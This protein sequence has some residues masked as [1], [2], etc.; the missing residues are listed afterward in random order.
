MVRKNK[1]QENII[2]NTNLGLLRDNFIIHDDLVKY[3]CEVERKQLIKIL[4]LSD[5][6]N[7]QDITKKYN[8]QYNFK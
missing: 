3:N 6:A 5:N 2:K 4:N 7:W 1:K 8:L